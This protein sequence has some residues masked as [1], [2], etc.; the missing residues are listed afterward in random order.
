MRACRLQSHLLRCLR[1]S[2]THSPKGY[3][4]QQPD[5]PD[6]HQAL[7]PTDVLSSKANDCTFR[8]LRVDGRPVPDPGLDWSV[9]D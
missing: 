4:A 5:F 1:I 8:Y 6:Q 9:G 7:C 2:H 3:I